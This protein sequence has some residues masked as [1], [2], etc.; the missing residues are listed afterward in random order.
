MLTLE[1]ENEFI[2]GIVLESGFA[3]RKKMTTRFQKL[4]LASSLVL[5]LF[6]ASCAPESDSP[7]PTDDRDKYIGTWSCAETSSQSGAST[8]DVTMRKNVTDDTQLLIDNFY[9][10]GTSH[11]ATVSKSGNSLTIGTQSISAR[12]VQGSGSIVSDTKINLTYTVNDGTGGSAAI[13][14]CSAILTKR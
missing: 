6:L 13:D 7:T 8:F 1:G 10:L 2:W 5:L 3:K 4:V 11:S 12:T 14:N 9:L